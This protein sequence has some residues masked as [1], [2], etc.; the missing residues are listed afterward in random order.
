MKAGGT[1]PNP[2]DAK[3]FISDQYLKMVD[4][5]PKLKQFANRSD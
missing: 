4:A 3:S 2:P 1:I 5:D